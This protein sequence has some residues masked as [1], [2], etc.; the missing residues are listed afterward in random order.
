MT[1]LSNIAHS[2]LVNQR[3]ARP[4]AGR[5]EETVRALGM[6]Q[7]QDYLGAL[8]A[9]GLRT[10]NATE[11]DIERALDEGRI[12]RTWPARGTL[13]FTAAEDV[14][15]LLDLL[16]RRVIQGAAGRYRQLGLDEA[17]FSR[18]RDWVRLALQ[19]GNRLTRPEL[20]RGLEKAGVSTAGQRG[21]HILG[22]LA[23]EGLICFGPRHGKQHTFVLLEEW[24]PDGRSLPRE[25]ALPEL[26]RRYFNGHGPAT[27]KDFAWWSGLTLTEAR[28]ALEQ[29]K[30]EL[31]EATYDGQAYWLVRGQSVPAKSSPAAPLQTIAHLLPGFDEYLV[32]YTNRDAVLDP[33]FTRAINAGGGMLNP[34]I[35]IDG[36]VVGTWKRSLSRQTVRVEPRW[37]MAPDAAQQG[38]YA[39]A[40]QAYAAFLGLQASI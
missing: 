2:R 22:R 3:I 25:Q 12:V 35:V 40:V 13:H 11:R 33:G 10:P 16:A 19:G 30:P 37:F 29:V 39:E 18:S 1:L 8:W 14:R 20:Y 15:W 38:A 34:V 5:P 6:L 24:V 31:D 32:G 27:V 28:K 9:V 7:A 17:D 23:M 26:A 21:I 4:S 36:Q